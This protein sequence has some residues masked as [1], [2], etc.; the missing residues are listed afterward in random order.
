[1][2]DVYQQFTVIDDSSCQIWCN[3]SRL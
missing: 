3:R 2:N 1:L